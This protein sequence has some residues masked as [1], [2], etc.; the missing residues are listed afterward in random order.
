MRMNAMNLNEPFSR[1]VGGIEKIFF[2]GAGLGVFWVHPCS[3]SPFWF[4]LGCYLSIF[5]SLLAFWM[6][7]MYMD[8]PLANFTA[9]FAFGLFGRNVT[10]NLAESEKYIQV[11]LV[12]WKGTEQ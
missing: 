1:M 3:L 9:F 8:E 10:M 4:I 6:N 5:T 7:Q 12:H 2:L 11:H